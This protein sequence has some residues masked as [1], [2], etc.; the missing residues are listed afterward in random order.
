MSDFLH[1]FGSSQRDE[2]SRSLSGIRVHGESSIHRT[3]SLCDVM[4]ESGVGVH[5]L[6]PFLCQARPHQVAAVRVIFTALGAVS[7]RPRLVTEKLC[8]RFLQ[9][10]GP[11]ML[12]S[13]LSLRPELLSSD[14]I[15]ILCNA[16]FRPRFAG[17][18]HTVV[19][20]LTTAKRNGFLRLLGDIFVACAHVRGDLARQ[21]VEWLLEIA[22]EEVGGTSV[23]VLQNGATRQEHVGSILDSWGV[24]PLLYLIMG[25]P[26]LSCVSA[27]E[28]VRLFEAC[29]RASRSKCNGCREPG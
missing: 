21:I 11:C 17:F 5:L 16:C 3:T 27:S 4:L 9:E 12:A 18:P 13:C 22:D 6:Y 29:V 7:R 28:L 1:M 2:P 8:E 10:K 26:P 25:A 20:S 23:A 19:A 14:T 15:E 24:Q